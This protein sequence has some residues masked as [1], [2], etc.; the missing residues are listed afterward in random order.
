VYTICMYTIFMN[1]CMDSDLRD[2]SPRYVFVYNTCMCNT[3][4]NMSMDSDLRHISHR[5]VCIYHTYVHYIH[6]H[7]H[8]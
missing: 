2:I 6:E 7:V 3:F 1:M 5:C 8:G 4:M